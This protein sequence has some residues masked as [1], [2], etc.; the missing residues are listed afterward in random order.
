[1]VKIQ[2]GIHLFH[3]STFSL[4][5]IGMF[6]ICVT[7]F[8]TLVSAAHGR[9]LSQSYHARNITLGPLSTPIYHLKP[10]QVLNSVLLNQTGV[11]W[12]RVEFDVEN[13]A[14]NDE[15]GIR[16]RS[17]ADRYTQLFWSMESLEQWQGTS[18][19]FNGDE[20]EVAL[21]T[22]TRILSRKERL[23]NSPSEDVNQVPLA[24][25]LSII[26]VITN[27]QV[28]GAKYRP[29]V[30]LVKKALMTETVD[31]RVQTRYRRD[32]RLLP[33]HCTA[34]MVDDASHC[35]LTAGHCNMYFAK[36]VIQF[37]V[38]ASGEQGQVRHPR[39]QYQYPLDK[40]SVQGSPEE[41]DAPVG[42]DWM[43][44]GVFPNSNT[45]RIPF[46][47]QR[48]AHTLFKGSEQQLG[49]SLVSLADAQR[50][51]AKNATRLQVTGY[52]ASASLQKG[53]TQQSHTGHFLGMSKS[54]GNMFEAIT[55][56]TDTTTHNSGSAVVDIS[57][58]RVVAIHNGDEESLEEKEQGA[59]VLYNH[60]TKITLPE[61]QR[62]LANPLGVCKRH[63]S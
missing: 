57:T 26:A 19:Y 39:P 24:P 41:T 51:P 36:S 13:T 37:H 45:G 11:D 32:A 22:S 15:V 61:L 40:E 30:K 10:N 29:P 47:S 62:A 7:L 3:T 33:E 14:I 25:Q 38:P 31:R 2:E 9:P 56:N 55:Y 58:G 53:L 43:V 4:W 63:S 8:I 34:F 17:S 20:V 46:Q 50:D 54:E 27:A 48:W 6:L 35:F 12:M 1:V 18:A 42:A 16:I 28:H 49:Q 5:Q 21:V 60:G 59:K 44:F 52:G 23:V